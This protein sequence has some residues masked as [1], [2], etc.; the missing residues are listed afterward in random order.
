MKKDF[1][2]LPVVSIN[3]EK[4]FLH[5]QLSSFDLSAL[6]VSTLFYVV[7]ATRIPRSK[8]VVSRT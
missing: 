5:L 2:A 7:R 1:N 3:A 6:V 4:S 8:T